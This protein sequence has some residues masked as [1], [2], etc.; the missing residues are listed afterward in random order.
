VDLFTGALGLV[1]LIVVIV[2]AVI[3]L[4]VFII[5][6]RTWYRTAAADEALVITGKA[7]RG[8]ETSKI[9]VISGGGLFVNPFTQRSSKL[10]LRSRSIEIKPTAQAANG[11]S[12]R[13]RALPLAGPRDRGIHDRG[14]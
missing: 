7:K 13:R 8:Q 1:I 12:S 3:A 4:I 5:I 6:S 14:A 11:D 9:E 10:S 2:I